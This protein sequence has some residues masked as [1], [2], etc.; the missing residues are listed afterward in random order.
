MKPTAALCWRLIAGRLASS[1]E[2]RGGAVPY[3]KQIAPHLGRPLGAQGAI[4]PGLHFAFFSEILKCGCPSFR[5][6]FRTYC[7]QHVTFLTNLGFSIF[8]NPL[9][10]AHFP[11]DKQS[12]LVKNGPKTTDKQ[13]K[14]PKM[15]QNIRIFWNFV[16]SVYTAFKL[17]L[18]PLF[19]MPS[20]DHKY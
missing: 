9:T 18:V 12:K 8:L 19:D 16:F 3:P 1:G 13:S 10:L 20:I 14:S 15:I 11:S 17:F 7:E 6:S 5:A 4:S 2:G